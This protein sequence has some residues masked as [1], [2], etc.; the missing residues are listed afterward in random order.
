VEKPKT[1]KTFEMV[2]TGY[3]A[4][5]EGGITQLPSL[6]IIALSS[7]LPLSAVPAFFVLCA[8]ESCF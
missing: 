8:P 4:A 3:E 5:G 2:S 6:I 7:A 1:L